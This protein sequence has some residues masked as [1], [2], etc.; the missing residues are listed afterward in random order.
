VLFRRY[1]NYVFLLIADT[2]AELIRTWW[3]NLLNS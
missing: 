1:Y 2:H 3:D